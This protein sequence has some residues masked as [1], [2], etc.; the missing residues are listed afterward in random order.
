M[1][2]RAPTRRRVARLG[3]RRRPRHRGRRRRAPRRAPSAS[4]STSGSATAI[5][6]ART[7]IAALAAAGVPIE[8]SPVRTR[9]RP[10]SSSR[11][12]PPSRGA[13]GARHRRG[14]RRRA[15][16]PRPR[17]RR[18]AARDGPRRPSGG[19]ARCDARGSRSSARRTPTAAPSHGVLDGD[20]GSTVSL[21]PFGGDVEGVTTEGLVYPLADEPLA[22]GSARGV[23]NVIARRRARQSRSGA[24]S[25]SWSESPATL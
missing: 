20:P 3:R 6:S 1:P 12:T 8:R 2:R 4:R 9:T 21:L 24:G 16:R 7:G 23:S 15:D 17:E 13:R 11:S 19:P 22:L 10:T 25:C 14:P 5:R 18:P